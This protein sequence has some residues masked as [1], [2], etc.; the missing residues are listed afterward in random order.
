[1]GRAGEAVLAVTHVDEARVPG[2][3][4]L[5]RATL[6]PEL[7]AHALFDPQREPDFLPLPEH[8]VDVA[9]T[10]HPRQHARHCRRALELSPV[11][12]RGLVLEKDATHELLCDRRTALRKDRA[13][14]RVR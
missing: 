10:D 11:L 4:L 13:A 2:E 8:H 14:A 7:R 5:F 9:P 3:D 1:L 12:L 6:R